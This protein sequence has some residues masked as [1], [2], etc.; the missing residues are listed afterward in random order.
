MRRICITLGISLMTFNASSSD[1]GINPS[2]LNIKVYKVA[3]SLSPLCTNL[4]TVLDKTASPTYMDF[5]SS[6]QI[7]QGSIASGT[8]PCIVIEMSDQI[9]F[10]PATTSTSQNCQQNVQKTLDVCHSGESSRLIDGT[11]VSC[12]S[13]DD[14][15]ALYLSTAS[16]TAA[17]G[18]N[19]NAFAAPTS[20]GDSAHGLNLGTPLVVSSSL[21]AEFVVNGTGKIS[22]SGGNQGTCDMGP[23]L[24]SFRY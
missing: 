13:G 24:F 18:Q 9:Q 17:P 11:P 12:T 6:P 19:N 7:A 4:I 1:S 20:T 14:H 2:N 22:D 15:V 10:T 23:P 3:V 21:T 8:Y 16:S 5:F